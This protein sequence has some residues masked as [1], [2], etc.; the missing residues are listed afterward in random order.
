[1]NPGPTGANGGARVRPWAQVAALVLE[2]QATHQACIDDHEK[3][4]DAMAL[5][6]A[7]FV[8]SMRVWL[9]LWCAIGSLVGAVVAGVMVWA[10]TRP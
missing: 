4:L 3:R 2:V 6:Q 1:M 7:T 8:G 9:A 10:L 5:A